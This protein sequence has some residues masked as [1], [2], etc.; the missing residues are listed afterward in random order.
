MCDSPRVEIDSMDSVNVNMLVNEG[1][2]GIAGG[3]RG[4]ERA[5]TD[6]EK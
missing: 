5:W 6:M 4:R 3:G 2:G 1:R